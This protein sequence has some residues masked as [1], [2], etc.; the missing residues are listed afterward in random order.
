MF[1]MNSGTVFHQRLFRTYMSR[2]QEGYKLYYN[3]CWPKSVLIKKC[4]LFAT[5]SLFCPDRK[6]KKGRQNARKGGR[7][8][9][10]RE[11]KIPFHTAP[12]LMRHMNEIFQRIGP[13]RQVCIPAT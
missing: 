13:L 9:E 12:V 7:E 6:R 10:E 8:N 5:V 1:F 11:E 4:A 3:K 2:F